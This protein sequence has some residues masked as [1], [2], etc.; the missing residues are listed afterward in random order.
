MI[1]L[2]VFELRGCRKALFI[3]KFLLTLFWIN[4]SMHSLSYLRDQA[5]P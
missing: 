1:R 3:L 2:F 4:A 5:I